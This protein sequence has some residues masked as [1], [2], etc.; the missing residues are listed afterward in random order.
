M[1]FLFFIRN[2]KF[3]V[4]VSHNS[5]RRLSVAAVMSS[6]NHFIIQWVIPRTVPRIPTQRIKSNWTVQKIK[7][8]QMLFCVCVWVCGVGRCVCVC[9]RVLFL[10][11]DP[12]SSFKLSVGEAWTA[13]WVWR[14]VYVCESSKQC[15]L[16]PERPGSAWKDALQRKAL[17]QAPGVQNKQTTK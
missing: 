3:E 8:Q 6:I 9:F 15:L 5:L 14:L 4:S 7:N 12:C 2:T 16:Q 17:A 1:F 11:R 13:G 10:S